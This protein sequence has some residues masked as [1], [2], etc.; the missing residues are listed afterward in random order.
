MPKANAD[1]WQRKLARNR[2]RDAETDCALRAHGWEVMR[3]WEHE[4]AAVA[5]D[6]IEAVVRRRLAQ[7]R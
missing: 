2:E 4:E 3:I 6:R 7:T 1:F 5:A